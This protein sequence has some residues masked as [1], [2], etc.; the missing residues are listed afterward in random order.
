MIDLRN[1]AGG[2]L[3]LQRHA[4]GVPHHVHRLA[5]F[6]IHAAQRLV[7]LGDVLRLQLAGRHPRAHLRFA[8]RAIGRLG[9][10]AGERVD[11]KLPQRAGVAFAQQLRQRFERDLLGRRR[12]APGQRH[13][14]LKRITAIN[15]RRPREG[16]VKL[17][18][19][20]VM[21]P[22]QQQFFA[23]RRQAIG[24]RA[25]ILVSLIA[26]N[27]ASDSCRPILCGLARTLELGRLADLAGDAV[28]DARK[29]LRQKLRQRRQLR[30]LEHRD[31]HA[32]LDAVGMRLDFLRLDRQHFGGAEVIVIVPLRVV[33]VERGV[34][35]GDRRL[36]QVIVDAAAAAG[37]FG[38]EL[39][40][41]ARAV[42]PARSIRCRA[43]R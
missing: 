27:S 31:Q 34:R 2:R 33:V 3:K 36:F 4:I 22:L 16:D 7:Q 10:K 1:G 20:H 37:V 43:W 13:F 28:A 39:D 6:Q 29:A 23:D 15:R 17:G 38:F 25:L 9:A 30:V 32:Q 12:A 42:G 40:R 24:R 8:E 5:I 41:H 19:H 14:D 11:Q 21:Q 26:L 35:I 18:R